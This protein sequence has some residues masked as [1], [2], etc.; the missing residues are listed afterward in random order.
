MTEKIGAENID[1]GAGIDTIVDVTV[2]PVK[3]QRGGGI[4][5]VPALGTGTE[6]RSQSTGRGRGRPLGAIIDRDLRNVGIETK[7]NPAIRQ[8]KG[9]NVR[10]KSLLRMTSLEECMYLF[11]ISYSFCEIA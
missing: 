8:K 5:G 2:T 7:R 9:K 1:Q 3:A 4:A 10:E 11:S 6:R